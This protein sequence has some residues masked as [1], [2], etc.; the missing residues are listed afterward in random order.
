M[1]YRILI[2][3]DDKSIASSIAAGV[4]RWGWTAQCVTNFQAVTEDF[5]SFAPQL[6]LMDLSLPFFN[7]YHWC[8]EI[9]KLSK[10]PVIFLSS[11][12]DNLNIVMAMNLGGDDF[13]AKPF[14]MEVLFAK[15]QALLRRT[16]EFAGQSSLL[17]QGQAVLNLDDASLQGPAG[18]T[19]L[20]KNELRIL[21]TLFE[22]K[23]QIV[24]RDTLMTRLWETD[25]YVDEN[26][27][28]V[29]INRLRRKLEPLGLVNLIQT[30][31][32]IGYFVE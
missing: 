2:V 7:G 23:G 22:A 19:S 29:N 8:A 16:Y 21:K 9:R 27:L 12:S 28:T 24:S 6:V 5:V 30:K 1:E 13:L 4:E 17:L 32:G 25:S 31:K 10:V 14:S 18:R 26:T 15:M 3:E 11:A 20:T